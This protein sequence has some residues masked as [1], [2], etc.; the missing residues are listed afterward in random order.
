MSDANHAPFKVELSRPVYIDDLGLQEYVTD[1][2]PSEDELKALG[3]R[4]KVDSLDA[5]SAHASVKLL[6]TGDVR[7]QASF[8]AS[9]TQ[10]CVVTLNPVSSDISS[11]FVTIY[12]HTSDDET[13]TDEEE[14]ADLE[15][16][17]D[18]PEPIID[19][20]IDIGEA[21]SEHL[22]L[23]IAPFPRVKG[24]TFDGYCIGT[25]GRNEPV[26]EKK[27][28]FAV[29]ERLKETPKTSE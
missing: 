29:L 1:I 6:P 8:Q 21:V 26:E 27:S 16:N 25:N 23:E 24:A 17:F 5:L 9:L 19:G 3:E 4:L 15:D 13:S 28:P 12:S 22:A 20:K 7:L 18:P 2:T 11:E 14:F 10:T